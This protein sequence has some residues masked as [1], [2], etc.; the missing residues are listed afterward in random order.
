MVETFS[1]PILGREVHFVLKDGLFRGQERAA[2]V[3]K[4]VDEQ[5]RIVNL[6]VLGDG[7]G[8]LLHE[9]PHTW[10]TTVMH[11]FKE[12]EWHLPEECL[13]HGGV[14]SC[15]LRWSKSF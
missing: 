9:E 11:G 10:V 14:D 1:V 4:V 5:L 3:V 7:D 2:L 13:G 15:S 8:K 6:Q 12:G